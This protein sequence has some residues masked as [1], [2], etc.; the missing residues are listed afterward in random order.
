MVGR[1]S[2]LKC[3]LKNLSPFFFPFLIV[4]EA[5]GKSTAV[6]WFF[7]QMATVAGAE[8]QHLGARSSIQVSHMRGRIPVI[9]AIA[10]VF[11][12]LQ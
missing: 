3:G 1:I 8:G 6:C 2:E 5:A 7:S 12:G 11:Q 4:W 9:G 10:A